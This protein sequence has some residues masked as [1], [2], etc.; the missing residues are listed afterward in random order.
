GINYLHIF[1]AYLVRK[2]KLNELF[3]EHEDSAIINEEV[4]SN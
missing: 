2:R 3:K 4:K 1:K